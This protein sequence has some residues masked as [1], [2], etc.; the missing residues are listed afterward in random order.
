MM[1]FLVIGLGSMGKRRIRCLLALGVQREHIIGFDVRNDRVEE[2]EKLYQVKTFQDFSTINLSKTDV[3]I[4]S[5]PPNLHMHYALIGASL[6]KHLFI[7][8]SVVDHEMDVLQKRIQERDIIVFPSC[9]MRF[10]PGP[11][12]IAHLLNQGLLGKIYAW[13]YQSG[14]YLPDWHPWEKIEDF[15]VS[16]KDT[17]GCREIVPFELSWL[18]K[19]FGSI[20]NIKAYRDQVGEFENEIDDIYLLQ[21][22]H[23]TGV[24][25]QLLV[26]VL[27]RA[28]VRHMRITAEKGSLVWDAFAN[29]I[30]LYTIEKAEWEILSLA[31]GTLENRYINP[32]EPYQKEIHLFL[33]CIK[34]KKQPV[35]TLEQDRAILELLYLAEKNAKQTL[36][37]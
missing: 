6:D 32:E 22:Q 37:I 3:W 8:A 34:D 21:V 30:R 27:S 25:G 28:P 7:E 10:F 20:V 11:E 36:E 16:Q 15:Y 18:T 2:A 26:D 13:Q 29:E 17:G 1:N 31:E 23:K 14:Q 19:I 4:I 35:Y 33:S 24:L 9:T 5:T 12:K